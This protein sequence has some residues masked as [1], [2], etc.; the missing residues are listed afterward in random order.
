[1]MTTDAEKSELAELAGF[2]ASVSG[3]LNSAICGFNKLNP[4][5]RG[6]GIAAMAIFLLMVL[7]TFTDVILRY[8]FNRPIAASVELTSMMMVIVVFFAVAYT[9]LSKAH[10]AMDLITGRLRRKPQLVLEGFANLMS[11]ALFALVIWRLILNGISSPQLTV[12]L[13]IP[14]KPFILIAAF[15][16]T[17][18][19]LMLIRDSLQ[20]IFESLRYKGKLWLLMVG[21]PVLLIIVVSYILV[22]TPINMSLPV[23]GIIGLVVMLLLFFTGMPVAFVLMSVGLVFLIYIRGAPAGFDI[24]G[25][26]WFDTV[27]SYGWSPLMFFLLMGYLSF[28]SGFGEDL[29]RIGYRFLGHVRGGLAM[30]TVAACTAFGAVVGDTLS[31]SIAM[32]AIGLP[33]MRKYKYDDKLAIGTLTCAGTIGMLIPPSI[34]FILY[35]ILAEQSIGELFIAGI[36]PGILCALMFMLIIYIQC[37]RNPTLGPS[38]PS[39]NWMERLGSLKSGGPIGALFLLVI[40]GIYAGIFTATEAGGIGAFG[41]LLFGFSMRR[42]NWQ[43]LTHALAEAAKFTAMAFTILGGATIFGYFVVVSQLPITMA[44]AVAA[45]NVPPIVVLIIIAI[46]IFILGCFLPALPLILITTPIFLPI[47]KTLGWDLVWFGVIIVMLMSLACITPPFG[48][49]LF[50]MKGVTQKPIG[51]IYLSVIPFVLAFIVVIAFII[52]FPPLSTWLPYLL[53]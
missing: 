25:K 18:L 15:G 42:L 10:V 38:V 34:G 21:I 8:L 14:F 11:V 27:S 16:C 49:N 51:N 41:A 36:I 31:G 6:I 46:I 3:V 5:V 35:S 40:G 48:I 43:R 50:V 47:A 24:L 7:F 39:S 45:M 17:L 4:F 20:N 22:T 37:R 32:T 28:Y 52:A 53:Q 2:R 9:Q 30:G 33:E 29:F 13:G 26:S 1:M 44:E 19:I 12:V 23:M